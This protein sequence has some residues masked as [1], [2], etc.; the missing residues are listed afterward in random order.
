M[1]SGEWQQIQVKLLAGKSEQLPAD[2]FSARALDAWAGHPDLLARAATAAAKGKDN[3]AR[4]ELR[5]TALGC[6]FLLLPLL[7][8][9]P[10]AKWSKQ[11]ALFKFAVLVQCCSEHMRSGARRDSLLRDLFGVSPELEL[12]DLDVTVD[13]GAVWEWMRDEEQPAAS[14]EFD[15]I[16]LGRPNVVSVAAHSVLRSFAWRLSGFGTCSLPYLWSNFLDVSARIE[17]GPDRIMVRMTSSPLHV[18]LRL[19]GLTSGSYVL[20]GID[21][22]PFYF[23]Q[24]A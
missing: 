22:R 18:I 9:L 15:A 11:P 21:P 7:E 4:Q 17:I 8:Q 23:F 6:V 1:P 10:A 20:D 19:S 16:Y 3:Y 2:A 5:S 12:E 24:E 14:M 13:A